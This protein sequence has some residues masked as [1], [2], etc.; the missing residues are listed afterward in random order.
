MIQ[1]IFLLSNSL[2][3]QCAR[4]RSENPLQSKDWSVEPGRISDAPKKERPC[5]TPF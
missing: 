5:V 4:D 3:T 1:R 2:P